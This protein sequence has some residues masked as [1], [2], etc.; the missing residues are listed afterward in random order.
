VLPVDRL[1]FAL[2]QAFDCRDLFVHRMGKSVVHQVLCRSRHRGK[3]EGRAFQLHAALGRLDTPF[4]ARVCLF[5]LACAA[6]KRFRL[7]GLIPCI[8]LRGVDT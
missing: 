2:V 4:L 8:Q 6:V 5:P 7:R 1:A 3:L